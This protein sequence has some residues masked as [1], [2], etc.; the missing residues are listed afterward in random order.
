MQITKHVE[1]HL[2][3]VWEPVFQFFLFVFHVFLKKKTTYI[4]RLHH[5]FPGKWLLRNGRWNCILIT[6]H[7]PDFGSASD[8]SCRMENFLQPIRSTTQIWIVTRHQYGILAFVSQ[9]WRREMWAVF[10][11][12]FS[13]VCIIR[14]FWK[15]SLFERTVNISNIRRTW[16]RNHNKTGNLYSLCLVFDRFSRVTHLN[17][18]FKKL[19]KPFLAFF[20][21][22]F[23]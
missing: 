17:V 13:A 8:W 1:F 19:I 16:G 9:W 23:P 14:Y 21:K 6:R 2:N 7:Y 12:L 4:L 10:S 3:P 22:L 18:V 15:T 5:W 11:G 20:P